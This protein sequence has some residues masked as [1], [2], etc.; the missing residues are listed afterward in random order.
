MDRKTLIWTIVF[1]LAGGYLVVRAMTG[2]MARTYIE[3]VDVEFVNVAAGGDEPEWIQAKPQ[4]AADHDPDELAT[5]PDENRVSWSR[6]ESASQKQYAEAVEEDPN[7][8]TYLLSIWRTIG[9]WL[10]ALFTLSIFSFLYKDSIFYKTAEAVV[11]GVSAAYWMVVAFWSTI[12]PNLIGKLS[13]AIVQAWA[14]PGLK[15]DLN[16]L[17]VVPLVLGAMLLWQL[18]PKG[19]WIS[20][21]PLAFF[22]GVFCGLRL[23]AY[24]HGD[25]LNQIRNAIIP[26]VVMESGS[27]DFWDSLRAVFL[28]GGLLVCLVYFFFSFEHKGIVGKTAKVGIWVLMITFGAGFG[29]TVMGR[30]AL[31]AIRLEFLFDDWLW[32]MYPPDTRL[33]M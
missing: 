2:G 1:V 28:V 22:I 23:M 16:L 4:V 29:Y 30:I 12:V 33:G 14:M 10:S 7:Q 27:F 18:A 17:Y 19:G 11:V 6:Y 15:E 31:H 8:T 21:W 3:A 5:Y 32:L 25:F 13:P 20:R 9:V 26:V 24:M